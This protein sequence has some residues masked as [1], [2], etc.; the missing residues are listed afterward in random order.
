MTLSNLLLV[1]NLT[2]HD[3]IPAPLWSLPFEIQMYLLLPG[4]FLLAG[5]WESRAPGRVGLLWLAAVGVVLVLWRMGANYQLLNFTPCFLP[6]ILAF[7][8]RNT[9]RTLPPAALFAYLLACAALMS[10]LVNRGVPETLAAWPLCLGLGL[11]IPRCRELRHPWIR[12][13]GKTIAR[14]SYGIYLLHGLA[15]HLAFGVLASRPPALQWACFLGA[16]VPGVWLAFHGLEEPGIAL[17]KRLAARLGRPRSMDR[18]PAAVSGD[19]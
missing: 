16:L 18:V 17:G 19:S 14:Y 7:T 1:Q 5:R 8:L 10:A 6:G 3:S 9:R 15:M 2:G 13:F 12:G 4:L 11:L